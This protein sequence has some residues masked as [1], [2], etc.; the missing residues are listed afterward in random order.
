MVINHLLTGM[1][2]QV[3]S[4]K[5][6]ARPWN[7]SAGPQKGNDRIPIIIFRCENVSFREGMSYVVAHGVFFLD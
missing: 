5:L 6:T 2:L 7:F 1:N 3:H 4:L